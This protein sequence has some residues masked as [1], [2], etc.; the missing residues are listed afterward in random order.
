MIPVN[1]MTAIVKI[2]IVTAMKK[3]KIAAIF[4]KGKEQ[5]R[6]AHGKG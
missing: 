3:N 2:V 1:V 5:I 4:K 6:R